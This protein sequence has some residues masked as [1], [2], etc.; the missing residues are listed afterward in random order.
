LPL[1]VIVFY[2]V[3]G[4]PFGVEAA[5]RAAGNFYALLGFLCLPFLWSLQEALMT[6]E[7]GSAFPE[8]SGGVVWVETAFGKEC[9]WM[10]GYLGWISGAT[11]NAIYPVLFLD[12]LTA[13]F[14]MDISMNPLGRWFVLAV[15]SCSLAYVN[16]L[17]LP[18]VGNMSVT[19]CVVAMSPFV[20]LCIVGAF[21]VQPSRWFQLPSPDAASFADD[22]DDT[23]RRWLS[24]ASSSFSNVLWRPFLNNLFWNGNSFDACG[25]FGADVE[26]PGESFPR[27]LMLSVVMMALS[28]FLPL[29]VALGASE[30]S[31]SDWVDGYLARA[32]SE[33]VGGWLGGWTVFAA[34]I[35]NIGMF[36]AELSADA[37]QLMGM[38]D[39]GYLPR[40]FSV[41]SRHGTPTYAILL[42]TL[43]IVVMTL[44]DLDGLIEMLNF[45]YSISLLMEYGAFL[46]LRITRA[47]LVRP[48]QIPMSTTACAIFFLPAIGGTLLVMSLATGRTLIFSVFVNIFG[49]AVYRM[50][51]RGIS[52]EKY[53]QVS[54]L[55]LMEVVG[56]HVAGEPESDLPL[57]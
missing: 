32:V 23:N 48:Y 22:D 12:Y 19:I 33:I 36:Q 31:Q 51:N 1:A 3:S 28:Y 41:R 54:P 34:A 50:R 53:E 52:M 27:A 13:A 38:A 10:A 43:V 40:I 11:D 24:E 17:G 25:S 4:G 30:A 7:L 6:A 18:L 29:L 5:V 16:W 55:E 15:C 37:Y 45:Q 56:E 14:Q 35:S 44:G 20:I 26:N 46:K 9:G 21:S 39:R 8:A 47:D 2:S 49:I 57:P 42:G